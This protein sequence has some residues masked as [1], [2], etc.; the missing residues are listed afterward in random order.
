MIR[1]LRI[2]NLII[3]EANKPFVIAEIG[4]NH[5]GSIDLCKKICLLLVRR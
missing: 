2:E 4:H 5:Q 3:N 1:E